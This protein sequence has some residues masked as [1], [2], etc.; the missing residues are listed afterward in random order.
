MEEDSSIN[1]TSGK[2]LLY[3]YQK[4]S[5]KELIKDMSSTRHP[6]L[7]PDG[8]KVFFFNDEIPHRGSISILDINDGH[9]DYYKLQSN[10]GSGISNAAFLDE[11][12]LIYTDGGKVYSYSLSDKNTTMVFDTRNTFIWE[13]SVS[14]NKRLIAAVSTDGILEA[15]KGSLQIYDTENKDSFETDYYLLAGWS[16]DGNKL[17]V[18]MKDLRMID[19]NTKKVE[20][21]GKELC[22]SIRVYRV[23]FIDDEN[24]LFSGGIAR[25]KTNLKDYDIEDMGLY[26]FNFAKRSGLKRLFKGKNVLELIDFIPGMW[27]DSDLIS[28]EK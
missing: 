24:M 7:S 13:L 9:V 20:V 19:F 2:L 14:P 26:R 8:N 17:F 21:I 5:K 12:N 1:V 28:T 4:D 11:N 18:R 25:Y 22:D 16:F 23:K 3:D 15:T 27:N 6:R 10:D